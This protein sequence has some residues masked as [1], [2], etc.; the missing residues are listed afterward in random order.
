MP[1]K[2]TSKDG[3]ERE[4]AA[5]RAEVEQLRVQVAEAQETLRAI[6]AGE[7]DALV[8]S[9]NDGERIFTLRGADE[10]YRMLVEQMAEGAVTLV[11]GAIHYANRRFAQMVGRPL[12]EVI[13]TGFSGHVT[14]H[15]RGRVQELLLHA[16]ADAVRG[17]VEL[18]RAGVQRLP[19]QLAL[20][21][22]ITNGLSAV[23]VV[24]TDL[25]DRI[26]TEEILASDRYSRAILDQAADAI[27]VCDTDGHVVLANGA[28][29]RLMRLG[30]GG[31]LSFGLSAWS[32]ASTAAAHRSS[33]LHDLALDAALRGNA[34]TGREVS[35]VAQDGVARN[36]LVSASPLRSEAGRIVGA[37]S[38]FTDITARN[39]AED[40][41]RTANEQLRTTV[42]ELRVAHEEVAAQNEELRV[43]QEALV[44]RN[45]DRE[46][47]QRALHESE[48]RLRLISDNL[49]D[50]AV[51]Q[52]TQDPDG[53][54]H[55]LYLSAGIEALTGIKTERALQDAKLLNQQVLPQ[56][57][58]ALQA[59][60]DASQRALAPLEFE[61][62]IR[63]ADGEIRWIMLHS[64]PRRH[65]DGYVI[66][67]GVQTDITERKRR[68]DRILRLTK[69][70]SVLSRVNEAIVRTH[71][72]AALF[73]QVCRI[74]A[75]E[76]GFPLVWIGLVRGEEVTPVAA[77][78]AA[79]EYLH[80]IRVETDGRLGAG[81][82]GTCIRESRAIVND[83]FDT[84]TRTAPWRMAALRYGFRASAAFPLRR[85]GQAVGALTLYASEPGAFDEEHLRLL[86]SLCADLS[87]ALDALQQEEYRA[88]AEEALTQSEDRLRLAVE[89]AELG[90]WDYD[91]QTGA[92][93]WSNRCK[94]LFGV[95]SDVHV[96]YPTFLDRLHPDDRA[97]VHAVV[98]AALD[99]AGDG[100]FDT[101]YRT[102]RPDGAERHVLAGGRAFF[103]LIDGQRRAVRFIGTVLD[104]TVR[105]QIEQQRDQLL[106][107]ERAARA[108][109]ERAGRMKDEFLA[110]LSHE[111]RTPLNAV[112]GWA[113]M[114]RRGKLSPEDAHEALEVIERNAFLQ[115]QLIE[116]LL[117]VSRIVAGKLKLEMQPVEVA[118]VA[119]EVLA[120]FR[121]EAETKGVQLAESLEIDMGQVYGDM[122]RLKQVLAN[123]LSN[124]IKFTPAGGRVRFILRRRQQRVVI[125]VQ[126]TGIGIAAEFLPH[127]F[128][129]FRQADASTTR[130]YRGLGLGLSI[131][132]QLVE[133]HGGTVRARSKGANQGAT[134][135]VELP[136]A[137]ALEA[138][139][140][141]ATDAGGA[142]DGLHRLR[143][144]VVDDDPEALRLLAR[145]VTEAGAEARTAESAAA[146]LSAIAEYRPDLLISDISMPVEDGYALLQR[147]RTLA[148]PERACVPAIAVTAFARDDDRRRALAAG[149]QGHLSKPV[150]PAALVVLASRVVRRSET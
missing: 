142:S 149:F 32:E 58:A 132:K 56:D 13:G 12:E 69:L 28:A 33:P 130:R 100:R 39:T 111:L 99:P 63:R 50:S 87:Y 66:W 96:D 38:T 42:E 72:E 62:R 121:P 20:S 31:D 15:D 108:E 29:R 6:G 112:L 129:R 17:E 131:V 127:L 124:A 104:V 9:T 55:F 3:R 2:P 93:S 91:P 75:E 8:V 110:T 46:A 126:D 26:R 119:R 68:D 102:R 60:V 10:A 98:Q 116:D 18:Q 61:M 65:P 135:V 117:D 82:T 106:D 122:G 141:G 143:V 5:L 113:Q 80:E 139:W 81:P 94:A 74:I 14:A 79:T 128:E 134:F 150:D 54:P 22:V 53:T 137:P 64:R 144:L 51:Y 107:S 85:G 73:A 95:P 70:Y 1:R 19:V 97:R 59:A 89:S 40:A 105:K 90:T 44:A 23:S 103:D 77:C 115:K 76:A 48:A 136:L 118:V 27:V 114:L 88:L 47:A 34:L 145:I 92:L 4:R 123:L 120:A 140:S 147:V 41:L 21:P 35:V 86:H 36:L 78:G 101:E 24:V 109:A 148:D 138:R 67:D 71:A 45:L 43:A 25:T 125:A 133:L 57:R 30:F 52:Y 37:V 7:V 84:N 11:D 146:A 16:A 83:D 49:P